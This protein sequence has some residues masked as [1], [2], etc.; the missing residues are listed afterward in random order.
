[1]SVTRP[2]AS[3]VDSLLLQRAAV[4]KALAALVSCTT[5]FVFTIYMVDN[6]LPASG[7]QFPSTAHFNMKYNVFL[8]L[9][10]FG[11]FIILT[12]AAHPNNCLWY[13]LML[14]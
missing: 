9:W 10:M 3:S 1:M 7:N 2:T 13:I 12:N 4:D 14:Q 8:Y 5:I 11:L 6:T